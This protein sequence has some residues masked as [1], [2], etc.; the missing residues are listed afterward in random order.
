MQTPTNEKQVEENMKEEEEK[1]EWDREPRERGWGRK[2]VEKEDRQG[3]QGAGWRKKTQHLG[4][5]E[6]VSLSANG[7]LKSQLAAQPRE[8][9]EMA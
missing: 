2:S 7:P 6:A 8:M 5:G 4:R 9:R 1:Q 3:G